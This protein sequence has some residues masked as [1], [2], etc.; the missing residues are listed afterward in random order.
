MPTKAI[1]L[2]KK[3]ITFGAS[4]ML[5]FSI[6]LSFTFENCIL[7]CVGFKSKGKLILRKIS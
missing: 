4:H 5:H 2:F 1:I 7:C 3:T 6:V